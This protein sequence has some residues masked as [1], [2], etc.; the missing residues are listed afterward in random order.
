MRSMYS[1][2]RLTVTA[3]VRQQPSRGAA[4]GD[5]DCDRVRGAAAERRSGGLSAVGMAADRWSGER[6]SSAR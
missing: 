2:E 6:Q 1:E 4:D 5:D 3:S